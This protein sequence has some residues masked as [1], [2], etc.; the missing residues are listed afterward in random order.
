LIIFV[1]K[2]IMFVAKLEEEFLCR[3]EEVLIRDDLTDGDKKNIIGKIFMEFEKKNKSQISKIILPPVKEKRK[4]TIYNK[5]MQEKMK[6]LE[7]TIIPSKLRFKK[8]S[9]MWIKD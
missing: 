5:F 7:N 9:T 8:A 2:L 3:I 1:D 4:L 6:E